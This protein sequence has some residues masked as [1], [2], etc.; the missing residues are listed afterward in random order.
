M[1]I[2]VGVAAKIGCKLSVEFFRL[3][4]SAAAWRL[5]GNRGLEVTSSSSSS[6]CDRIGREFY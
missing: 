1:R 6:I 5:L 4:K 2:D 3:G